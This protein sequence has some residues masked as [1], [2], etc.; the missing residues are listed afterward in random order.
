MDTIVQELQ[1]NIS[2]K[3]VDV[4]LQ[5]QE[6]IYI[7]TEQSN[8]NEPEFLQRHADIPEYVSSGPDNDITLT[9]LSR[10]RRRRQRTRKMKRKKKSLQ[11]HPECFEDSKY[12][13]ESQCSSDNSITDSDNRIRKNKKDDSTEKYKDDTLIEQEH[14]QISDEQSDGKNRSV[15]KS[16]F[17]SQML[18]SLI[19][20]I[21]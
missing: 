3:N 18:F 7:N 13:D 6:S 2:R 4:T 1:A 19:L 14:I 10:L 21:P 11:E 20:L 15:R 16:T 12:S 8:D 5:K 17:M 9:K